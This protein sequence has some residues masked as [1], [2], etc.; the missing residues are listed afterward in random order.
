M[1]QRHDSYHR[2]YSIIYC[3]AATVANSLQVLDSAVDPH[4]DVTDSS[5]ADK[6]GV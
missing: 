2:K 6:V 5:V 1:Y 4:A 3:Q